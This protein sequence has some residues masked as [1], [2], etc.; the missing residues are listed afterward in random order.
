MFRKTG[1]S[2]ASPWKVAGV[3]AEAQTTEIFDTSNDS[4]TEADLQ[5]ARDALAKAKATLAKT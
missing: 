3:N 4:K 1:S 2:V 5:A